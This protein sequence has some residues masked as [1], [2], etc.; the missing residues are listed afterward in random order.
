MGFGPG[1]EVVPGYPLIGMLGRGGFGEVWKARAPGGLHVALKFVPLAGESGA[2][3]LRALEI[4]KEVR[5]PHL[6]SVV[7]A[8]QLSG[9][10]IVAM[11]LAERTLRDRFYEAKGQG[12]DGIPAPEVHEFFLEAAKGLDYLNEPRRTASGEEQPS[13]QH[14]DVKPQNLLLMGGSVKVAD[15][16]LARVLQNSLTTH[17]GGMTPEYAAPEFFHGKVASHSDQYSLAATYCHMRGGYPPFQGSHAEVMHGHLT[18]PPDV[19]RLPPAEQPVVGRALAKDP[20]DRYSSCGEFVR[21]LIAAPGA[22][23]PRPEKD[24]S[25][26]PPRR[27]HA[28][29]LLVPGASVEQGGTA[30]FEGAVIADVPPPAVST[31]DH[32]DAESTPIPIPA[33]PRRRRWTHAKSILVSLVAGTIP[34]VGAWF[35][36][37]AVYSWTT[38]GVDLT[39]ALFWWITYGSAE[40]AYARGDA[41]SKAGDADRAIVAYS[42]AIWLDPTVESYYFSRGL[43]HRY[44]KG[45]W[46][47]ALDDFSEAIRLEPASQV[48]YKCRA[49]ILASCPD[50]GYRDGRRAIEDATRACELSGWKDVDYLNVLAAAYAEA[51]DFQKAIEWQEKAL[52]LLTDANQ[53]PS[54][55]ERLG[56][57]QAGKPYH[58]PS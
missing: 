46:R 49:E 52:N 20:R 18:Q 27:E 23:V 56:L 40:E 16:G 42:E 4:I 19:S 35:I 8:W 25:T 50:A 48:S 28:S 57:Y 43:K 11:E 21:E 38:P 5:H 15:F 32:H 34:I 41:F 3:E 53:R 14:R 58:M 36:Q 39:Y 6:L 22:V 55:E 51:G 33:R 2:I 31:D 12:F 13:I 37:G 7:G 17:T 45:D 26:L 1:D 54:F 29:D 47:R 10:L 30:D 44:A 9:D 24:L